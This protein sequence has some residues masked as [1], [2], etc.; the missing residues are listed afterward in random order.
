ME[1]ENALDGSRVLLYLAKE[2]KVESIWKLEKLEQALLKKNLAKKIIQKF[3]SM[4]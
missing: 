4:N 1:K 3:L 2:K